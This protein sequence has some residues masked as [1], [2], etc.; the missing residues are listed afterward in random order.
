MLQIRG[1]VC[2]IE[3]EEGRF[4][5]Y[6][7]HIV[8]QVNGC[9]KSGVW[10]HSEYFLHYRLFIRNGSETDLKDINLDS[11]FVRTAVIDARCSEGLHRAHVDRCRTTIE[12]LQGAESGH[13]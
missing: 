2:R 4:W 1:E 11:R 13:S 3:V 7:K 12:R 10:L 8:A 9:S 5:I 6:A